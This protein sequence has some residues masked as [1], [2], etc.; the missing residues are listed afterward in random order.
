MTLKPR[1]RKNW[2]SGKKAEEDKM[3]LKKLVLQNIGAFLNRNEINFECNLPIILIGGLNGR[4]KTTIL[5]SV[6]VALYG[7]RSGNLIGNH[8][9]F[10]EYLY[11]ISNK[12][13]ESVE[14]FIE[15]S[16]QVNADKELWVSALSEITESI[17]FTSKKSGWSGFTGANCSIFGPSIN[18]TLSL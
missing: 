1:K 16:F 8:Q 11:K 5:E 7:K 9:K 13:G 12:N 15:L 18:A 2:L 6:L 4:G 17:S 3:K 14:C 10:E